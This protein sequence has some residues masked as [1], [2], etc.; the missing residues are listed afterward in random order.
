MTID[1]LP[2]LPALFP[3]PL[4]FL[5]ILVGLWN[6]HRGNSFWVGFLLSLFFTPIGGAFLIATT[7]TRN[8]KAVETSRSPQEDEMRIDREDDPRNRFGQGEGILGMPEFELQ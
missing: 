6:N 3:I 5:A 8:K 2:L 1:L 7:T 4:W